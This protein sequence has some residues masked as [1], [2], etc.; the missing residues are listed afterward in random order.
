MNL[1]LTQPEYR[2]VDAIFGM[3]PDA[4]HMVVCAIPTASKAWVLDGDEKEFRGLLETLYEELEMKPKASISRVVD[5][6]EAILG[7]DEDWEIH[8]SFVATTE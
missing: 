3:H 4:H 8:P 5:K 6:V 7:D 1:T 2:A